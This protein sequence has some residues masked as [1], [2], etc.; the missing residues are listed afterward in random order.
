MT[1]NVTIQPGKSI[2]K[3][4]PLD[5]E[6]GVGSLTL[7]GYLKDL[8]DKYANNEAAVFHSEDGVERWTYRQMWDK[9]VAVAKALLASGVGK[10]TRVGILMT[11]RLEFLSATF[12]TSLAGGIATTM[13]TFSTSAELET[14]LKNSCCSVLLLEPNV[15]KK[16]FSQMVAELVPEIA[17][18]A[19]GTIQSVDYPYL[20]SVVSLA[21]TNHGAIESWNAWLDKGRSISEEFV[22]ATAALVEPSDPGFLFFSSGSTGKP[23]GILSAHRGVCLQLW[24]CAHWLQLDE[25]TRCWSANGFFWSGNFTFGIGGTFSS[26]GCM[27]L[28]RTFQPEEALDLMEKEKVG[29]IFAWPHQ[30]AQLVDAKNWLDVDL[31]SLKF[32]DTHSPV[33][34]HPTI[35]STWSDATSAYGNT[36]TFTLV[37]AFPSGTADEVR[38]GSHGIP[39]AGNTIRIVDPLTGETVALG[40]RGEIAVKGPTLMMGYIGIPLEESLDDEGYLRTGDGGYFDEEG[41]LIWEGRLNDIIKT[42]GANVSPVEIDAVIAQCPGVKI[43]KTVGIADDLL[44]EL[45]VACIVVADGATVTEADVKAFAKQTLASFKVP[46]KVLFFAEEE[47]ETT[48]SAK[49]KSSELK[50]LAAERL[51]AQS[52]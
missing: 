52:A 6:A 37:S 51:E 11:N 42:G 21:D 10:G 4:E 38:A 43:T 14:L 29:Y 1:F 7:G 23:K 39:L 26:G 8:V 22:S 20:R 41:R 30:W 24:R 44:G 9:S 17:S 45:V 15:L 25:G 13:S 16:N 35:N 32:I 48:G 3:G 18:G 47:L 46:R 36:E 12:G 33:A 28:Q 2:V 50:K 31:S 34:Q 27:V 19:P 49:V 5:Q 40:E